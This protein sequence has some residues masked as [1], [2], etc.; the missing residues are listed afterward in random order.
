ME[1]RLAA[2]AERVSKW[3]TEHSR[4]LKQLEEEQQEV[5]PQDF[6]LYYYKLYSH[7]NNGFYFD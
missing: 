7:H 5:E 6:L 1:K 2:L 3:H 4:K